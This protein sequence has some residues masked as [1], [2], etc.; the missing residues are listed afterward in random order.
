MVY[1]VYTDE[2]AGAPKTVM[3]VADN[4]RAAE[5]VVQQNWEGCKVLKVE[6][7]K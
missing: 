7:D 1:T 2:S 6:K 4:K 5:V 3:V